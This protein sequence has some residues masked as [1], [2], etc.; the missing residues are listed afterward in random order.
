[1]ATLKGKRASL[2]IMGGLDEKEGTGDI[3]RKDGTM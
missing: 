1:M 2:S 3:R